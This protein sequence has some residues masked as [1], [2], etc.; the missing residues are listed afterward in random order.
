MIEQQFGPF[1]AYALAEKGF[2][3]VMCR[4]FLHFVARYERLPTYNKALYTAMHHL[5][6]ARGERSVIRGA[7]VTQLS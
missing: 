5:F 7:G 2:I 4:K 1:S 6:V 3:S